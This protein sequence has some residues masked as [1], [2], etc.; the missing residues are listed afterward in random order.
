MRTAM[1]AIALW[2]V[3]DVLY[4]KGLQFAEGL[5]LNASRIVHHVVQQ[6]PGWSVK[7]STLMKQ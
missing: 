2:T 6:Q 5:L 1:A 4:T 3:Q 7:I